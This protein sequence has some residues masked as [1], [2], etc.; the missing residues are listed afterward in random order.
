MRVSA[1]ESNIF[2]GFFIAFSSHLNLLER[3]ELK[4]KIILSFGIDETSLCKKSIKCDTKKFMY[5]HSFFSSVFF[6]FR[7]IEGVLVK[8]G[9][10]EPQID[11]SYVFTPSI[12]R[13]IQFLSQVITSSHYP[14]L[15]E[16]ETS[17]G[18]TSIITHLAKSTGNN[19]FRIN[20]HENTDVQVLCSHQMTPKIY[21]INLHS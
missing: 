2:I 16:G 10:L 9:P 11:N 21:S 12:R 7:E 13:N 19:V 5:N 18:K 4:K 17:T 14:I 15:L 20:N 3:D 1:I 6:A 8:K